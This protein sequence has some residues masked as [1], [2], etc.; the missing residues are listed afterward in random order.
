MREGDNAELIK[1]KK[2]KTMPEAAFQKPIG[3]VIPFKFE[4]FGKLNIN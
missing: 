1:F 4:N 2:E 3:K